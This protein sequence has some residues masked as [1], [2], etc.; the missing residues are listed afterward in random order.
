MKW[1][2]LALLLCASPLQAQQLQGLDKYLNRASSGALWLGMGADLGTTWA[3]LRD[4]GREANPLL[5]KGARTITITSVGI[6]ALSDWQAHILSERGHA[7]K[8]AIV[9]GA[10]AALHFW[11]ASRNLKVGRE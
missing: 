11:I 2:L 6:T 1:A 3:A 4:G 8:V 9:R 10:V 7:K 5:G